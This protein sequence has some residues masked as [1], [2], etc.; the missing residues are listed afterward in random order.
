MADRTESS[1]RIQ[2][3]VEHVM[4]VIADFEAYPDWTGA[5]KQA[6]VLERD[7]QGRATQ[8]HFVLD[9]GAVKDDYVLGYTWVSPLEL[10]WQLVRAQL[11]KGMDG[12]YVLT[13][14]GDGCDVTYRLAVDLRVPMLGMLKRRAEKA[15]VDT[16]LRELK[17][18]V[19]QL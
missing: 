8:V 4:A 11:L 17:N 1:L 6:E 3:P 2:A 16:A 9:A 10:R 19:E 13:P 5:V 14:D 7:A 15:I 18:R 12:S